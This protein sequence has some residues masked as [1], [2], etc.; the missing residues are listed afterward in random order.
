VAYL[1]VS[2]SRTPG[3]ARAFRW[4]ESRGDFVEVPVELV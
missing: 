3:E 4:E 2:D 1:V